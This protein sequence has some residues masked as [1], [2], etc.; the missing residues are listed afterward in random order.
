[1]KNPLSNKL[2]ATSI[3]CLLI[4]IALGLLSR[5]LGLTFWQPANPFLHNL[6]VFQHMPE[7]PEIVFVGTSK[8]QAGILPVVIEK[9][10][11]LK[12][13]ED[14]DV[15]NLTQAGAGIRANH[16]VLRDIL[17]GDK[18]P[19]LLILEVHDLGF[20]SNSPLINNIY[21]QYFAS[22]RDILLSFDR[23]IFV[24][25]VSPRAQGFIRD[26]ANLFWLVTN[27]PWQSQSREHLEE[28]ASNGGAIPFPVETDKSKMTPEELALTKKIEKANMRHVKWLGKQ[29]KY[30][31]EGVAD[32]R[33]RDLIALCKERNIPLIIIHLPVQLELFDDFKYR[34]HLIFIEY[35]TRVCEQEGI[36]FID[37]Q[38]RNIAVGKD[39][40]WDRIHLNEVGATT[41]SK[42]LAGKVVVPELEALSHSPQL[43]TEAPD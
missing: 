28:I 8:G 31:I 43:T 41:V 17:K 19:K 13:G 14:H 15:F 4:L 20:N 26:A 3:F 39:G 6:Y 16:L 37:L 24:S 11:L 34:N 22:Q 33:F 9:E 42:Y 18:T 1:M 7:T 12:T 30:E 29:V 10:I 21:F 40:F 25:G 23:S 32:R 35:V 38:N 27:N 2:L 36:K 5:R